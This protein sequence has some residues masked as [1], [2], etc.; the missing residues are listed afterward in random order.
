MESELGWVVEQQYRTLDE[1]RRLSQ[2]ELRC[3]NGSLRQQLLLGTIRE[4]A[5][6][7]RLEKQCED[8][9]RLWQQ[10]SNIEWHNL[11]SQ[12]ESNLSLGQW[13]TESQHDEFE[14]ESID[15]DSP[16]MWQP[17]ENRDA[18]IV[19]QQRLWSQ[20][21]N[22]KVEK[23]SALSTVDQHFPSA[24]FPDEPPPPYELHGCSE[25]RSPM[26]WEENE[27]RQLET[28]ESPPI[29]RVRFVSTPDIIQPT[30]APQ[31]SIAP[32]S[33][34]QEPPKRRRESKKRVVGLCRKRNN[35]TAV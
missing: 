19:E 32:R 12:D 3:E 2:E 23:P 17:P 4:D 18:F 31:Q 21:Q 28:Q 14:I 29:P 22:K 1:T 16:A 9:Q 15:L 13:N 7:K 5:L 6:N 8:E 26:L 27:H 24:V 10:L 34:I 30:V 33:V 25:I 20:L 35:R 11:Q